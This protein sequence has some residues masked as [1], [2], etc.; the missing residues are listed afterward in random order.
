MGEDLKHHRLSVRK[1]KRRSL[2]LT[3]RRLYQRRRRAVLLAIL[4]IG[5]SLY[6]LYL[7]FFSG[8]PGQSNSSQLS[9]QINPSSIA[10]KLKEAVAARN[11]KP[12]VFAGVPKEKM[13]LYTPASTGDVIVIGFHQAD[14]PRAYSM[15]SKDDYLTSESTAIIRQRISRGENPLSFIMKSRGR[16]SSRTSAA[17]I[18]LKHGSLV[19]APVRGVV[20][21]IKQ[22]YMYGRYR[23]FHVE[24]QPDGHPGIRIAII[25]LS[26]PAVR[27]G[28]HTEIG[29]TIIGRV[30][31][32]NTFKSQIENYLPRHYDHT[33]LQVNPFI[34]GQ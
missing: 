9:S 29:K 25:H 2:L 27:V 11:S 33:H 13:D 23:D 14:N 28:Q 30:R 34:P 17:D 10:R 21:K 22:Y 12:F 18:V 26:R 1:N 16:G 20:T 7:A 31:C 8:G 6:F 5:L 15:R 32:L 3:R 4:G 24:I 19:R